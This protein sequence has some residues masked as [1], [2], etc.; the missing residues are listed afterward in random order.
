M[1]PPR[2]SPLELNALLTAPDVSTLRAEAE[3]RYREGYRCFKLKVG[4]GRLSDD[5]LRIEALL[6]LGDALRLRLDA[7]R[8]WSLVETQTLMAALPPARI[9][10]L[11]EPLADLSDYP[12]LLADCPC[13]WRLTKVCWLWK[14]GVH[15]WLCGC[16][17]PWCW[18]PNLRWR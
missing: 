13:P 8:S 14:T 7:N 5:L 18:G 3:Q 17:N 1:Q 10:Y 11:E 9:E 16:S 4:Q 2:S 6:G 12:A 15:R